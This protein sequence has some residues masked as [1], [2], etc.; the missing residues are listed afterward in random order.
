M[1]D[2]NCENYS[3][4]YSCTYPNIRFIQIN[5]EECEESGFIN[6]NY[7]MKKN[8]TGW[9]KALYYFSTH[10]RKHPYV[11]FIED[12]VF[13]NS[14]ETIQN[15]DKKYPDSDIL[16]ADCKK[17]SECRSWPHW[18]VTEINLE[19]PYFMSMV[20]ATRLSQSL[21]THIKKYASDNKTLFFLEAL[22]PTIAK[23]YNLKYSS[24]LELITVVWRRNW[25]EKLI[26]TGF[27]YHPIKNIERHNILRKKKKPSLK[28]LILKVLPK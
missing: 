1:I 6:V 25:K 7:L 15:I 5:N 13:F 20:C 21:L 19:P 18:K 27:I 17:R 26:N 14:E 23:S 10:E 24:P 8:V 11:W 22:F 12:D 28:S 3:E 9:E 2:D 4:T 16:A